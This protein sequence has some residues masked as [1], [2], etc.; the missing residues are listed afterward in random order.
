MGSRTQWDTSTNFSWEEI[1]SKGSFM[2]HK[3][4]KNK[5]QIKNTKKIIK[6]TPIPVQENS[7]IRFFIKANID[8]IVLSMRS[9]N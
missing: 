2:S 1:A 3:K 9:K 7:G 6:N 8:S 5:D 4:I